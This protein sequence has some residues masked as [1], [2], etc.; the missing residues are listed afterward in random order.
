MKAFIQKKY[1]NTGFVISII[2]LLSI[3]IL[4]YLNIKRHLEDEVW[5]DNALMIIQTSEILVS[6]LTDA[7]SN[8]CGYIITGNPVFLQGCNAAI[9]QVDSVFGGIGNLMTGNL[10][11]KPLLDSISLLIFER[12]RNMQKSMDLLNKLRGS[13]EQI[14]LTIQVRAA[15]NGISSIVERIQSVESQKLKLRMREAEAG[16]GSTIIYLMVG[17]AAGVLILVLCISLINHNITQRIKFEK[18]LEESR[19]WFSTS[20]RSIGDAVIVTNHIGDIVLMNPVAVTLTGWTEE[21]AKG[22]YLSHVFNV[23]NE[24]TGRKIDNPVIEVFRTGSVAGLANHS[25][26]I[27]KS[28]KEIPIDDSAAPVKADDGSIL[29]VVLVFRDI[30]QRRIAELELLSSRKFIQRIADSIPNVLYLYELSAPR[31]TYTNHKIEEILGYT[32]KEVIEMKEDFFEKFMHPDDYRKLRSRYKIYCNAVDN[33]I[34]EN[35]YRVKNSAGEWRWLHSFDIVFTRDNDGIPVQILGTALDVTEKRNLE[36]ELRKYNLHLE[37]VIAK[38]T[39]ELKLT[40]EKLQL[41]I[42]EKIKAEKEIAE[43]EEKFRSLVENS[44]VGI[45]IIQ[46]QKFVYV[47]P[48]FER[49]YGY[50]EEELTGSDVNALIFED[51]RELVNEKMRKRINGVEISIHYCYRAKRKNGEVFDVEVMGAKMDFR[52]KVAIIGTLSDITER[53]LAEEGLKKSLMEK[54]LLLKEIHHRVK[55]NLQVIASLL[56]L[57]AKYIFDKRDLEI[58]NKSKSRIE[59]MSLIHEKLYKSEDLANIDMGTYLKD[60]TGYLLKAYS[61]RIP[62]VNIAV[63]AEKVTLGIDTAIP[64]GLIINEL[65]SNALK[66]AFPNK[67]KGN[68]NIKL[69]PKDDFIYVEVFDNGVG[70]PKDFDVCAA[71]SLGLQLVNTLIKQLDGNLKVHTNN[72]SA[73]EFEFRELK[74]RERI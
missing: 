52:G 32:S 42:M 68:I 71:G 22:V 58:L 18:A 34:V 26:L 50:E 66:H 74:Y 16:S 62:H 27:S 63:T 31:I 41:E 56:K 40:N 14:E 25:V 46:D 55:N 28:G 59:T 8:R 73:F 48:K 1:V 51:D 5:I 29:G 19:N 44:L 53:K 57:Q 37:E 23:I 20:L 61:D 12:R 13:R 3:N 38:R 7:E 49:I 6:K 15:L 60:L 67:R 11:A 54:E 2:I 47:N 36:E 39:S 65:V 30:S 69:S 35:L 33:E 64:C 70:L 43:A 24:D 9:I 4:A 21:E 10:K 45:Y 17:S 72:G